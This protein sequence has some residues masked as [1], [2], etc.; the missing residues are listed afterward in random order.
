MFAELI[1]EPGT[2][3]T[4]P[5]DV[6]QEADSLVKEFRAEEAR[7][8]FGTLERIEGKPSFDRL[9]EHYQRLKGK[10]QDARAV[11]K[12]NRDSAKWRDIV[13]L[14]VPEAAQF[15]DLLTR[16]ANRPELLT[17]ELR[18]DVLRTGASGA[19]SHLAIEHA[20]RL[21]GFQDYTYAVS[22]LFRKRKGQDAEQEPEAA[23][24]EVEGV[25]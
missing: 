4:T 18:G 7:Y 15:P 16:L 3:L 25:Q 19:A 22:V 11:Y 5:L 8:L 2:T 1:A 10:Y 12:R 20:A 6:R 14:E 21:C 17:D 23:P 13:A 24:D 9:D